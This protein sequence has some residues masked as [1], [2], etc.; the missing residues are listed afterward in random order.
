TGEPAK[1][2]AMKSQQARGGEGEA[3]EAPRQRRSGHGPIAMQDAC[4]TRPGGAG[5]SACSGPTP[6]GTNGE[7]PTPRTQEAGEGD[8]NAPEDGHHSTRMRS[9][10]AG[11]HGRGTARRDRPR[12]P[13]PA[14]A[15]APGKGSAHARLAGRPR[16]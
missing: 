6:L 1:R 9:A 16:P 13:S 7:G 14:A 11:P 5:I 4:R 8:R 2:T 12:E 10:G 15:F 3:P